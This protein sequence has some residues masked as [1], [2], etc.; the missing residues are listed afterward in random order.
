MG[1]D[2]GTRQLPEF[3]RNLKASDWPYRPG[4]QNSDNHVFSR[5]LL[6]HFQKVSCPDIFNPS[7]ITDLVQIFRIVGT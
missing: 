6:I 1:M 5:R 4:R 7:L 2:D 3:V